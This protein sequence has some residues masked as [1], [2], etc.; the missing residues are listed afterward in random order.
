MYNL[1]GY[2]KTTFQHFVELTQEEIQIKMSHNEEADE[3]LWVEKLYSRIYNAWDNISNY[4]NFKLSVV[5]ED[6]NIY[7]IDDTTFCVIIRFKE[8]KNIDPSNLEDI[9]EQISS[10]SSKS[11]IVNW[12][13]EKQSKWEIWLYKGAGHKDNWPPPDMYSPFIVPNDY[14][15]FADNDDD[16]DKCISA[17]KNDMPKFLKEH[18]NPSILTEFSEDIKKLENYENTLEIFNRMIDYPSEDAITILEDLFVDI[19]EEKANMLSDDVYTI[20][21]YYYN[22]NLS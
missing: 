12:N 13:N 4:N 18:W 14:K 16:L 20:I 19:T 15:V 17:F 2:S 9:Y 21:G 7:P 8:V 5:I 6:L 1:L 11:A 3:P 22:I 10:N